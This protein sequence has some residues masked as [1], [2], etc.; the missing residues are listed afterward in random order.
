MEGL[1]PI[2]PALLPAEVR[3]GTQADRDLYA[4]ALAF[5]SLLTRQLAT[6]I[7]SSMHPEG[8]E[9]DAATAA[10][11][12]MLPDALARGVTEAGG[13]GLA[14]SLYAALKGKP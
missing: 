14:P 12:D 2:D 1:P 4:S 6:Q 3:Q 9:Q 10:L 5:E 11:D 8:E 13:L 7:T